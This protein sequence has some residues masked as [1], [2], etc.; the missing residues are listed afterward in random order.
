MIIIPDTVVYFGNWLRDFSQAVDVGTLSR[1]ISKGS[2]RMLVW[3]MSF[4]AHGYGTEEFEVGISATAMISSKTMMFT[5]TKTDL[6][7]L[8]VSYPLIQL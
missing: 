2:I 4:L 7:C 1:G 6:M 8:R 5:I 3:V